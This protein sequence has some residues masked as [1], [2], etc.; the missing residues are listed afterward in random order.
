MYEYNKETGRVGIRGL[1]GAGALPDISGEDADYRSNKSD[2]FDTETNKTVQFREILELNDCIRKKGFSKK[3]LKFSS[4]RNLK[5]KS[6]LGIN[7]LELVILVPF[8]VQSNSIMTA[9]G[10]VA[11]G[12]ADS[13]I[14]LQLYKALFKLYSRGF[15]ATEGKDSDISFHVS[16]ACYNYCQTGEF[17]VTDGKTAL[18]D[19]IREADKLANLYNH[20]IEKVSDMG[21][22][23]ILRLLNRNKDFPFCSELLDLYAQNSRETVEVYKFCF[24]I[25]GHLIF[26]ENQMDRDS[27]LIY[28]FYRNNKEREEIIEEVFSNEENL[29]FTR[30]ILQRGI[31]ESGKADKNRIELHSDF[32]RKHLMGS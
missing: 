3:T 19:L 4:G 10:L 29:L 6:D 31:D 13:T 18:R 12:R 2:M 7:D 32:K 11:Y 27:N 26:N 9:R 25:I 1:R 24:Y 21:E 14:I 28:R 17:K 23:A 5:I 15:L 30:K 8:M 20:R 22:N 16:A